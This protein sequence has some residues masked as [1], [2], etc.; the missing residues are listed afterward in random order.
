MTTPTPFVS[1]AELADLLG[2]SIA[3]ID[4][5]R[6]AGMP[7]H[8]PSGGQGALFFDPGE[9]VEWV[10]GAPAEVFVR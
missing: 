7:S 10:R 6:R 4:R 8:R 3:T 9:V 2:V 1:R 5:W